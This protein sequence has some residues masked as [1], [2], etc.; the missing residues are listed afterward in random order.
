MKAD[1]ILSVLMDD[2]KYK[3]RVEELKALD[4]S[5]DYVRR[6]A[7]TLEAAKVIEHKAQQREQAAIQ[8]QAEFAE[9]MKKQ[10][11]QLISALKEKEQELD[12]KIEND[13]KQYADL[14]EVMQKAMA[15]RK[16]ADKL[17]QQANE[18]MQKANAEMQLV[19][20]EKAVMAKKMSK[21]LEAING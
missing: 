2:K 8:K 4:A 17:L 12:R 9:Y 13:R 3:T 11:A 15:D 21:L 14:R 7:A 19:R 5:L 10:E 16:E 6:I 18:L 20:N 1:Q